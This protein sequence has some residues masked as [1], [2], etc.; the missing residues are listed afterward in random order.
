MSPQLGKFCRLFYP[1]SG[2]CI[3]GSSSSFLLTRLFS[4]PF[5]VV[6]PQNLPQVWSPWSFPF[7]LLTLPSS[8]LHLPQHLSK[9]FQEW[10]SLSLFCGW[11]SGC[12]SLSILTPS[13]TKLRS[14]THA[15]DLS[16]TTKHDARGSG[17]I[18]DAIVLRSGVTWFNPRGHSFVWYNV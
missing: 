6:L 13:R 8:F 7:L 10:S 16:I 14:Q 3:T 5:P 18:Q 9:W 11:R 15:L 17:K 12:I 2:L 4:W 1:C